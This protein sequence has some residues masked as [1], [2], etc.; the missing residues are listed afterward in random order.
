MHRLFC[1]LLLLCTVVTASAQQRRPRVHLIATGGTIASTGGASQLSGEQLARA[2]PGL[3]S[4]AELSV[5]QFSNVGSSAITPEHWR[6]LA[7]RVGELVRTRPELDGVV[8][9]HGTDTME[10]TALFLDLTLAV[11][12]P[13][14][15]TGSMRPADAVGADGPANLLNAVRLAASPGARDRGVLVLMNDEI[16]AARNVV[17]TSTTRVDAFRSAAGGPLGVVDPDAVVFHAPAPA[18]RNAP[19]FDLGRLPPLPR[20][21]VVFSYGGA[22]SVAV[23]AFLEAGAAGLV[24]A[25]VGRG[26]VPPAQRR[27]MIRAAERGVVVVVGSRTGEGR[28]P[29]S[30]FGSLAP[31]GP[32]ARGAVL[33]ASGLNPQKARVLLMLAL[34]RTRDAREIASLFEQF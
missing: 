13:V 28:V 14:V 16:F 7:E 30:Q 15:V 26:N 22:D 11:A 2:V 25:G 8:I 20:V 9:T 3:E 12:R 31:G 23:D 21:D 10:E 24:I 1:A 32:A 29:V 18:A 5:E 6:R 19:A 33:G 4:V 27:A 17:K 34:A